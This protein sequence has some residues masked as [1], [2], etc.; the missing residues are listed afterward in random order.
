MN[1]FRVFAVFMFSNPVNGFLTSSNL[2][3]GST[4]CLRVDGEK[5]VLEK[6]ELASTA[7]PRQVPRVAVSF[8]GDNPAPKKE[9]QNSI[10]SD[11]KKSMETI[12][13]D[14]SVGQDIADAIEKFSS[15]PA[16]FVPHTAVSFNDEP[17]VEE[18]TRPY[19]AVSDGKKGSPLAHVDRKIEAYLEKII[20]EGVPLEPKSSSSSTPLSSIPHQAVSFSSNEDLP[21]PG[22]KDSPIQ[23]KAVT[24]NPDDLALKQKE[25]K[26]SLATSIAKKA[27]NILP[28]PWKR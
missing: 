9:P 20:E 16:N 10:V 26:R 14:Q 28:A 8:P 5:G 13:D 17:I 6:S 1:L 2:R 23:H 12:R 25:K 22:K 21:L 11:T 7:T 3:F 24:F 4:S 18:D 15:V 27:Q 19:K